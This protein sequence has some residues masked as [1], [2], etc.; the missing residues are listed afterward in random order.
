MQKTIVLLVP[1]SPHDRGILQLHYNDS[2]T[3]IKHLGKPL[4]AQRFASTHQPR[5]LDT[6]VLATLISMLE[7]TNPHSGHI[8]SI[9]VSVIMSWICFWNL[10]NSLGQ[11]LVHSICYF[12]L[13]ISPDQWWW[14]PRPFEGEQYC[15]SH[16]RVRRFFYFQPFLIVNIMMEANSN[17]ISSLAQKALLLLY[18]HVCLCSKYFGFMKICWTLVK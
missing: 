16:F 9:D 1:L 17:T 3:N 6:C 11:V 8:F 10:D 12:I 14:S 2:N 7:S 5:A 18:L 4:Y 15:L 13:K